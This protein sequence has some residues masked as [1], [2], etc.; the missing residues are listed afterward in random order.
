M[1]GSI[2]D[3]TF[4]NK[5]LDWSVQGKPSS[6]DWGEWRKALACLRDGHPKRLRYALGSWIDHGYDKW[7][8]FIDLQTHRLYRYEE[9]VG[10]QFYIHHGYQNRPRGGWY[11][12]PFVHEAP[13]KPDGCLRAHVVQLRQGRFQCKG[14]ASVLPDTN[15]PPPATFPDVVSKLT[16][17]QQYLLANLEYSVDA[18]HA[19][20]DAI[21]NRTALAVSD[22][23]YFKDTQAASFQLRMETG[24]RTNQVTAT[25]YVP[26]RADDNN[27]YRAEATGLLAIVS[28]IEAICKF[29][30]IHEGEIIVGCDGASALN[31]ALHD[32]WT[33]RVSDKQH[34]ILQCIHEARARLP[35][36]IKLRQRWVRGHSDNTMPY[37]R[38]TRTQQLNVDCDEGAKEFAQIPPPLARPTSVSGDAWHLCLRGSRLVHNV[39]ETLRQ[40][41][42][43]PDLVA[44]WN[45]DNRLSEANHQ[46]INWEA[47]KK[48]TKSA[49]RQRVIGI[50]KL[51]SGN[52]ATNDNM[53]AWGFRGCTKCA[54]CG[55][56]VETADHVLSCTNVE[57]VNKWDAAIDALDI[58]LRNKGTNP[59]LR[60]IITH[61]L[62]AWKRGHSWTLQGVPAPFRVL[63]VEQNDIGWKNFMFGFVSVRWGALQQEHY[64]RCNSRRSGAKW[65]RD[66]IP[67]MWEIVWSQWLH[68][69]SIVH[70]NHETTG[71]RPMDAVDQDIHT[72]IALGEPHR[73]PP[74]LRRFFR[75]PLNRLLRMNALDRRLWLTTAQRLRHLV[76]SLLV[77]HDGLSTQRRT[78][79]RWLSTVP[80]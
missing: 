21:E 33:I 71:D 2:T 28:L 72:E 4:I 15:A 56:P 74:H 50:M 67:Q 64:D 66:L 60:T 38:M 20:A 45:N 7:E 39:E 43:D 51:Y 40:W 9:G 75:G 23:S 22:G 78:M 3:T 42:H 68:R 6:G 27:S 8:W 35:P 58:V 57:A 48:A 63:Q 11:Q 19:I 69:N 1:T 46:L 59:Y 5:N 70:S 52:C 55:H 16:A 37:E 54:R 18:V 77:D 13:D 73:C 62:K 32:E 65:I 76:T 44:K 34:D 25:Q 61:R 17:T 47:Q 36:N 26:G 12:G 41:I 79:R 14:F 10:W 29:R 80:S 30:Q 24:Q 49:S 31:I 53:T